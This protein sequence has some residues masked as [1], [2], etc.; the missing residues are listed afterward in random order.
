MVSFQLTFLFF[1]KLTL[2]NW[3]PFHLN[4]INLRSRAPNAYW[5]VGW[6]F[7]QE[8]L[9]RAEP[10]HPS[11]PLFKAKAPPFG[12]CWP[13]WLGAAVSVGSRGAV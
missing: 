10:D 3:E 9:L 12:G 11:F 4:A 8:I 6:T 2:E 1:A 5:D 13:Q 7:E